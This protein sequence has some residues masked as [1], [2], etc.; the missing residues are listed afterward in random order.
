VLDVVG[1]DTALATADDA[2]REELLAGRAQSLNAQTAPFQG[3]VWAEP[4]ELDGH[5]R[6]VRSRAHTLDEPLTS[7]ARDYAAFVQSLA[8][9]RTLLE[10]RLRDPLL[11]PAPVTPLANVA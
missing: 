4:V 7:V 2:T 8:S 5:L 11:Q 9:Q 10:R 3:L 1:A 6:R